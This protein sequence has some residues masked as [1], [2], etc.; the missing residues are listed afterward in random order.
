MREFSKAVLARSSIL[1][2]FTQGLSGTANG[3]SEMFGEDVRA[4]LERKGWTQKA[5]Q[6]G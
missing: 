2:A 4:E 5:G 3:H 6:A 1:E